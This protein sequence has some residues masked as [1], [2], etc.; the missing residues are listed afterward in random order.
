MVKL[1][2]PRT[3]IGP[4]IGAKGRPSQGG[5]NGVATDILD[6]VEGAANLDRRKQLSS[7]EGGKERALLELPARPLVPGLLHRPRPRDPLA[8]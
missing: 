6:I 2:T 5:V 1:L 3:T 8:N 7:L 4:A